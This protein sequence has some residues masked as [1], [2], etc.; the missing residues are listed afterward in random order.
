[1]IL[2]LVVR[3]WLLQLL[4]ILIFLVLLSPFKW[5]IREGSK[6][7]RCEMSMMKPNYVELSVH[8]QS[9]YA[10]KYRLFH[11]FDG[12]HEKGTPGS[13]CLPVIFVP[14]S[15]GHYR[16]VRSLAS[17][18]LTMPNAQTCH[19]FYAVDFLEE[20][21]AFSARL[22]K[23]QAHYVNDAIKYLAGLFPHTDSVILV[24]HSF[25]GVVLRMLPTL[26]NY[27][28]KNHRNF[29]I[30]IASPHVRPPL[31][32]SLDLDMLYESLAPRMVN[33]SIASGSADI[34]VPA[35]LSVVKDTGS[36]TVNLRVEKVSHASANPNH[37]AMV[38]DQTL[39][40][41]IATLIHS[42]SEKTAKLRAGDRIG[43][44]LQGEYLTRR[45]YFSPSGQSLVCD[46]VVGEEDSGAS[47]TGSWLREGVC[48]K[49]DDESKNQVCI[50]LK[51]Q[52]PFQVSTVEEY[53]E[54]VEVYTTK[55]YTI[56]RDGRTL[57]L[58]D[59]TRLHVERLPGATRPLATVTGTVT[60]F[61]EYTTRIVGSNSSGMVILRYNCGASKL[62]GHSL[63]YWSEGI[64]DWENVYNNIRAALPTV[65]THNASTQDYQLNALDLL[66]GTAIP[67]KPS[68]SK[69]RLAIKA[70][71]NRAL[72]LTFT[73]PSPSTDHRRRLI[74]VAAYDAD[75]LG[76]FSMIY[77]DGHHELVAES[78]TH[79]L[80]L[81]LEGSSGEAGDAMVWVRPNY[82]HSFVLTL[83]EEPSRLF[84]ELYSAAV[85][86]SV[87]Y[88][89]PAILIILLG[90]T[91]LFE[92]RQGV[93][94]TLLAM[95][96]SLWVIL[97]TYSLAY[98]MVR[99]LTSIGGDRWKWIFTL[100]L[101]FLLPISTGLRVLI[102][103]PLL[104]VVY[105]GL[106]DN[107]LCLLWALAPKLLKVAFDIRNLAISM[108]ELG[109][110]NTIRHETSLKFFWS[111]AS[112]I[113]VFE[114]IIDMS[115]GISL[116]GSTR[117]TMT[118]TSAAALAK[119]DHPTLMMTA[120]IWAV[121]LVVL[122]YTLYKPYYLSIVHFTLQ[123]ARVL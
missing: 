60:Q 66:L 47:H 62:L 59:S 109:W 80:Y 28:V 23:Q 112:F 51:H 91:A 8:V 86:R 120:R 6:C 77:P 111:I 117:T 39:L 48:S 14:G 73:L 42:I 69:I 92:V 22:L 53:G 76:R 40:L 3:R 121:V 24:G 12:W 83:T 7:E 82:R 16:Q 33:V 122:C 106:T 70:P 20:F 5:V 71:L 32:V 103:V 64:A 87:R 58:D 102:Q 44:I 114:L 104:M 90:R 116:S 43:K 68:A 75:H 21:V 85:L 46:R 108:G 61:T 27:V 74:S 105:G 65:F 93:V 79:N 38:W 45:D 19:K 88:G 34:Q 36:Q 95:A 100:A 81:Y 9:P 118:G 57:I 89:L 2:K 115:L 41:R 25:G 26:E 35:Q 17:T 63:G 123:L 49:K 30:T 97:L 29:V 67:I 37:V 56:Q 18:V 99:R 78:D 50:L 13:K 55:T 84:I 54:G 107:L 31:D 98:V 113:P 119:N 1:M 11:Y 4:A 15:A 10:Y 72:S 94:A 52:G 101:L 110:W 96:R